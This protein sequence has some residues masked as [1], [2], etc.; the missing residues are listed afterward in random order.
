MNNDLISRSTVIEILQAKADMAVSTNAQMVYLNAARMVK[1]IPAVD[2]EPVRHGEWIYDPN[3]T[4]WGIG[5][6]VCSECH[7]KNN[8]LPCNEFKN[9]L[10]FAGSNFCPH[11]GA[12]MD[13]GADND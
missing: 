11:C 9:P 10:R 2:A 5:G 7:T 4:D 13:G 3:A 6:Y 8:N 12:R 1:K